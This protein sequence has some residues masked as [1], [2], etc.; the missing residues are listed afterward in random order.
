MRLEDLKIKDL[1]EITSKVLTQ[2]ILLLFLYS[3][4]SNE[5]KV[6]VTVVSHMVSL[7]IYFAYM[8]YLNIVKVNNI[9]KSNH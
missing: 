5:G 3:H 7:C 9:I 4:S 8:S 6:R 1:T 2:P